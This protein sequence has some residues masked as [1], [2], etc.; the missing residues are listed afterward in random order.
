M[1]LPQNG[2]MKITCFSDEPPELSWFNI[3]AIFPSFVLYSLDESGCKTET[4]ISIDTYR[5]PITCKLGNKR[6]NWIHTYIEH[7]TDIAVLSRRLW[8][9]NSAPTRR[10]IGDESER[11]EIRLVILLLLLPCFLTAA[12]ATQCHELPPRAAFSRVWVGGVGKGSV[13]EEG[14][15]EGE[16]RGSHGFGCVTWC[17]WYKLEHIN[18]EAGEFQRPLDQNLVRRIK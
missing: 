15:A 16:K 14:G 3:G 12:S 11:I 9:L 1:L 13:G 10:V 4:I 18:W 6:E 17:V 5:I 7:L 2:R 8:Q